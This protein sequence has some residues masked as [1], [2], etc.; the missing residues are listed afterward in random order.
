MWR[1]ALALALVGSA[2]AGMG[3]RRPGIVV[4]R[5]TTTAQERPSEAGGV[6][7]LARN[8]AGAARAAG[9]EVYETSD[10]G[11]ERGALRGRRM[12][13]FT[14]SLKMTPKEMDEVRAFVAA[15]GRVLYFAGLPAVL[16]SS[17]RRA[18]RPACATWTFP[19]CVCRPI[20]RR[21]STRGPS[22]SP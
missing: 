9:L 12:A 3:A 7:R 15:G 1:A 18:L 4:V 13:I 17:R 22:I 14:F 5:G 20:P 8:V 19:W 16:A 10:Q 2:L 11:V 6:P 21:G